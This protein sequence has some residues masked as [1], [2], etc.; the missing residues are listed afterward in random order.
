M[1]YVEKQL[2]NGSEFH[3]CPSTGCLVVVMGC[4]GNIALLAV[5]SAVMKMRHFPH[6]RRF[7]IIW[8]SG[9]RSLQSLLVLQSFTIVYNLAG[10]AVELW[11]TYTFKHTSLPCAG[12]PG[13]VW[14]NPYLVGVRV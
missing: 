8:S 2:G 14:T 5:P 11:V 1:S 10:E 3:C 12:M 4:G 13:F 7:C 9:H 6:D